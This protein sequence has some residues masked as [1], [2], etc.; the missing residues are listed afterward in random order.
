MKPHTFTYDIAQR[1]A[2][3]ALNEDQGIR[4]DIVQKVLGW[5]RARDIK[6]LASPFDHIDDAYQCRH[7]TRF[8][9]QVSA[10]FKKNAAFASAEGTRAAEL[11]FIE[12]EQLCGM[13]NDQLYDLEGAL[14]SGEPC[15]RYSLDTLRLVRKVKR[16][17]SDTLG[18]FSDFV[19]VLPRE[20]KVTAGASSTRPR[21][22]S[23]PHKKL[24]VRGLPCTPGAQKYLKALYRY[25]GYEKL[26]FKTVHSNRVVTVPKNWK[27]ERTI[28]CEP[29]GNL[30]LQ[31]ALDGY[32]K[33]RLRAKLGI[34]L[35]DQSR[36]Q[37]LAREASV[38]D[39]YS[40]LDL[41]MASDT[42]A[43]N[44]VVMLLPFD[45]WSFAAD[46]RSPL[47][48][49]F[50]KTFKYAKFSSMGNGA[51]FTLETLIFGSIVK[52][53]TNKPFAVY[54]D[55]IVVSTDAVEMVLH[56]LDLFG[57]KV[58]KDKSFTSGPFRESCGKDWYLGVDVTPF[59]LRC[60]SKMK[61]ELCHI[62]NGL[63]A[64][65]RPG[66]LVWELL[67]NM[68]Q[69]NSLPFVP[70]NESSISGVWIDIQTAY[71]K[72]LVVYN[73]R[74]KDDAR[75]QDLQFRAFVPKS[76]DLPIRNS[77]TLSLWY[78][79]T[80][81]RDGNIKSGGGYPELFWKTIKTT[82]TSTSSVPLFTHKFVRK[83]VGWVT[84][85]QATPVHVYYWTDYLTRRNSAG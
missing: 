28:A 84:P 1:Y 85:A 82:C 57:F 26:S 73:R 49:G 35:S 80:R 72:K 81:N 69:E 47:G 42:L 14:I 16:I 6:R 24:R 56:L 34:D 36:N 48:D 22:E 45:W 76:K 32:I 19:E 83:W 52:A 44:T 74:G 53:C 43:F 46:V 7:Q 33:R 70:F 66:G 64:I 50:G 38:S 79:N 13:T 15:E 17:I 62:V 78:F 23:Q 55:D 54:G 60:Q 31:L 30:A 40:T 18:E 11:G 10:F 12:A 27:T 51:T 77:Q 29:E 9:R 71:T 61:V 4:E 75:Y 67:A 2:L 59:Y 37:E 21:R 58:N 5:I 3:D 8:L 63:A 68:V 41:S 65:S 25:Y 20:V 39:E